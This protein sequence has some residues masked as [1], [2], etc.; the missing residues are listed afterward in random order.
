MHIGRRAHFSGGA[1]VR[2]S[3]N[4]EGLKA[5][6][7]LDLLGW[8]GGGL[9]AVAYV[10]VSTGRLAPS[11]VTFQGLN[12]VGAALL[13]MAAVKHGAV[14]NAVMNVA[15]IGFGAHAL[16]SGVV[17]R[18]RLRATRPEPASM[19][20]SATASSGCDRTGTPRERPAHCLGQGVRL[21][22]RSAPVRQADPARRRTPLRTPLRTACDPQ[23]PASPQKRPALPT[24]AL[25]D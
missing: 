22:L 9:G 25:P 18:R 15:W 5:L 19:T 11:A 7:T 23:R 12:M 3:R 1:T 8:F 2:W 4:V 14:S 13:G 21:E 20:P 16:L 6:S 17:R 10:L 24:G